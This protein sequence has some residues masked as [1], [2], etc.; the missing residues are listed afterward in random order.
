MQY[1]MFSM[2]LGGP[3]LQAKPKR[4]VI[5]LQRV[6]FIWLPFFLFWPDGWPLDDA[7][8]QASDAAH[9]LCIQPLET[10]LIFD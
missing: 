6:F 9:D 3:L 10:V 5:L 8:A 7:T 4:C 2:N 1:I